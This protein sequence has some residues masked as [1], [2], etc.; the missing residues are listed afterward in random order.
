MKN[1]AKKNVKVVEYTDE[2]GQDFSGISRNTITVDENYRYLSKNPFRKL[3]EFLIYRV[4][5]TPFAALYCR[6]KFRYR[7]VGREKLRDA[8]NR[9]Y[10]VYSNHTLMAGDAFFPSLISFPLRVRVIVNADNIS[11]KATK[12]FIECCG[13]IPLPTKLSGMKHFLTAIRFYCQK[14][15]V[16]QVYPEAH[17]WPYYV[18]IRR[19]PS[20]GFV[21]PIRMGLPVFTS[22]VTYQKKGCR[23]TPAVTIYV[24]GP[25]Y[26][27]EGQPERKQAAELCD[28]VFETMQ[29]RAKNSTY[30]AIRYVKVSKDE[31]GSAE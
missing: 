7:I 12:G 1:D 3:L 22:T 14:K 4:I 18:G 6:L 10:F 11:V 17:I 21:Y 13:A 29:K 2:S 23:K 19:F 26:P 24:D 5:M 30:E 31:E 28:A 20:A 15:N 9:G 25:F 8:G 16:I 27:T